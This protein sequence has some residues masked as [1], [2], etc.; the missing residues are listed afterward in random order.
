[1]VGS[2]SLDALAVGFGLGAIGVDLIITVL[3]WAL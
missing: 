3:T 2:V 1:M